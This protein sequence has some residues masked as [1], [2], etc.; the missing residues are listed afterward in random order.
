MALKLK[1]ASE[2]AQA[3]FILYPMSYNDN[4]YF[5]AYFLSL[6]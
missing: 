1:L 6:F 4:W 3:S 2:A 5:I